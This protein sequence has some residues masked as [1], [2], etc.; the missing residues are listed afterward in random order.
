MFNIATSLIKQSE[1]WGHF[2]GGSDDAERSLEQDPEDEIHK[3][4]S[5]PGGKKET[6]GYRGQSALKVE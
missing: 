1:L 6:G 2:G 5:H 4:E 3:P